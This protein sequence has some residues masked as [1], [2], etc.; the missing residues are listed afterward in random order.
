MSELAGEWIAITGGSKG[1]GAGIAQR[2]VAGRANVVLIARSPDELDVA[3]A[4]LRELARPEQQVL[5]IVAD[6]ADRASVRNLF[7]EL[8][9]QL[10]R[11]DHFVA[12]A[13]T[14]RV[15]PFLELDDDQIDAIVALNFTG[16]IQCMREAAKLISRSTSPNRSILVVSSVR[17]SGAVPGR[18]IYSATKAGVNQAA[19]VA[20][21]ELA[22][23]GIRVNVL[24]PGI[25]ETPLTAGN[26]GPFA[27]AVRNVP[28]GRAALPS[29]LGEAAY[30]L[31]SPAAAFITG[32]NVAVDGGESLK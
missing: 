17:A 21:A 3:A 8:K 11:L 18:L 32:I 22:S 30:F 25:T 24:S 13:G 20:A 5:T 12:N 28:L 23:L 2:A 15:T 29:D 7:A 9:S 6:V 16:T 19:R 4:R 26:P 27:E 1:I 31:C 14:G 10:P